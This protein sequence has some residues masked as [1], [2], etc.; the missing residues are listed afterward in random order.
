MSW[1]VFAVGKPA[2]VAAKIK[3]DLSRIVC[4]EPEETLKTNACQMVELALSAFPP[5][6]AVKVEASGSQSVPDAATPAVA[7]NNLTLKIGPIWGFIE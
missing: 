7:L 2:A 4:R 1:S 3:Q 6:S 5:N